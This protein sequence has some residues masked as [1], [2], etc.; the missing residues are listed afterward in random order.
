MQDIF[1][2]YFGKTYL[3]N[4]ILISFAI[5]LT[6]IIMCIISYYIQNELDNIKKITLDKFIDTCQTGDIIITRW[7][8][9][10]IGYRLFCKYCHVCIIYKNKF[11]EKFLI[12]THPAEYD[13]NDLNKK[14]PISGVN[15]YP[16]KERVSNYQ[17]KCY[18]LKLKGNKKI[19]SFH[20]N[21]YKDIQFPTDFRFS[22][23]KNWFYNKVDI[24][25]TKND[26]YDTM[27]CSE[28]CGYILQD[29]GILNKN[30]KISTLSPDSF[31]F[32]KD[33]NNDTLYN[34]PIYI[35]NEQE[36]MINDIKSLE[37]K[38]N[39]SNKYMKIS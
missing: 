3:F 23:L 13:E 39:N 16:L 31:E 5:L 21:K 4:I 33:D 29:L 28:L 15:I 6:I 8:Y 25:T 17:G 18:F 36:S 32:L 7:E 19:K 9:I 38:F 22:F 14:F 11:G 1:V 30:I 24:N 37:E 35:M 12:E 10:D 34:K 27:Y 2:Y 26:N 20:F